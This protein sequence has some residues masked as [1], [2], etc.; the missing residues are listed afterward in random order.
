MHQIP[1]LGTKPTFKDT[2][3]ISSSAPKTSLSLSSCHQNS[4]MSYTKSFS[5]HHKNV[6]TRSLRIK[7]NHKTFHQHTPPS[8]LVPLVSSQ[9]LKKKKAGQYPDPKPP[10]RFPSMTGVEYD[11]PLCATITPQSPC[12]SAHGPPDST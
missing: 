8:P 7:F 9:S 2:L 4:H 1:S 5:F 3:H 6:L 12:R 11:G 10:P